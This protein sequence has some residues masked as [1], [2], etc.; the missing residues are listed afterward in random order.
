MTAEW[1][2]AVRE[3][4]ISSLRRQLAGGADVNARDRRGQTGL[5]LAAE[6]GHVEVVGALLAAGAGLN[7]AAK[8]GL[9]AL[10]RA[11]LNRHADV[12]RML[13]KAGADRSL[14][15]SGAPGFAGKTAFELAE[16]QG[17]TEMMEMLRPAR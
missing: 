2:R 12:A 11:V 8:Y 14:Q 5:M 3:G 15:G 10:M 6:R 7:Y 17:S 1:E 13:V 4:D 16:A 9:T